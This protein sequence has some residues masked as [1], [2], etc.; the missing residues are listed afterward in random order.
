MQGHYNVFVFFSFLSL[1][2]LLCAFEVVDFRIRAAMRVAYGLCLCGV[3]EEEKEESWVW[4]RR[5]RSRSR[6]N[7]WWDWE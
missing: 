3:Q 5:R 2:L 6:R 7:R 1:V 4:R